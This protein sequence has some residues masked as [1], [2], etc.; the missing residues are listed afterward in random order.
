MAS[1]TVTR[2]KSATL[3]TTTVDT[4]TLKGTPGEVEVLNRSGEADIS[5][6]VGTTNHPPVD[7]ADKG[8][9]C[10]VVRA[11]ESLVVPVE[12]RRDPV[13]SDRIIVK[14][15]GNGNAYTV[16]GIG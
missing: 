1:N 7:P 5:F 3:S 14:L 15:I 11:G 9:D 13:A 2:V 4:V 6:T 10:Y 16:T 12:R 8:D